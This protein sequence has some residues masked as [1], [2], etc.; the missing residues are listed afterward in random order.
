MKKNTFQRIE[1]IFMAGLL[2]FSVLGMSGCGTEAAKTE[3]E[4]VTLIEPVGVAKSIV[5]PEY[6]DMYKSEIVSGYVCPAVSELAYGYSI[7]F[8]SFAKMPG[9]LIKKG[10]ALV[11]GDTKSVDE[12]IKNMEETI[13][14]Q[15]ESHEEQAAELKKKLEDDKKD[16]EEKLEQFEFMESIEDIVKE[17]FKQKDG[18]FIFPGEGDV[19]K[20][21][22][23]DIGQ[24]NYW[25]RTYR[26]Y[27]SSHRYALMTYERDKINVEKEQKLYELDHQH[28]LDT[29]ASL[30]KERAEKVLYSNVNGTVVSINAITGIQRGVPVI[31]E[32]GSWVAKNMPMVAVG[33]LSKKEIRCKFVSRSTMNTAIDVYAI[34]HGKR[35]EVEYQALTSEE[36][37]RLQSRDGTVYSAFTVL[38]PDDSVGYGDFGTIVIVKDRHDNVMAVPSECLSKDDSGSYLYVYDGSKYVATYVKTGMSDGLYTEI[39]SGLEPT[40]QI[41]SELKIKSGSKTAQLSKGRILSEHMTQGV[42]FYPS[43]KEV[44]NP[45]K[46]GTTYVTEV[47]VKRNQRV[48]KGDIL[49]KVRVVSD[50]IEIERQERQ[51]LRLNEQLEDLI[52]TNDKDGKNDKSIKS[53]KEQIEKAESSLNEIKSNGAITN[54]R[55]SS[56]GVITELFRY[57]AGDI[58]AYNTQIARIA[59]ESSCFIIANDQDGKLSYGN[60]V[61]VMYEDRNGEVTMVNGTVVTANSMCLSSS[62]NVGAALISLSGEDMET[63]VKKTNTASAVG[64]WDVAYFSI[65]A[66]L[67][68]MDEVLVVPRAAVTEYGGSTYVTVRQEDGTLKS[69]A[70]ISGGSDTNGYWVAEGLTEGMTI[71]WE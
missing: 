57:Q 58:I 29:L 37:K 23:D 59:D 20:V 45:V 1:A 49:I 36:Y 68:V 17:P 60:T 47:C 19:S 71:C 38:D 65:A 27:D 9:E 2:S 33:D 53:K 4:N 51:L 50:E 48:E 12:Q 69:V 32:K 5:N 56:T 54:V 44:T 63:L 14:N 66:N 55:A 24:Y 34:I 13:K 28:N 22:A 7:N 8:S 43:T 30:K 10:S 70:F 18:S 21:S 26:A 40:A 15:E 3:E 61:T 39:L 11:Y 67:R 46:Y 35:Y 62:L 25:I 16:Y 52:K 6:R 42:Y 41:R 64:L 31:R